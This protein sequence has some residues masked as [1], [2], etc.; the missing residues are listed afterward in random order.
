VNRRMLGR[1]GLEVSAQG[2]GGVASTE[3]VGGD[4]PRNNVVR[5]NLLRDNLPDL[6]SD[7]SGEDN[8][9]PNNSCSSSSPPGLCGDPPQS[10]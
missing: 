3:P 10:P 5:D 4:V 8:D 2:L 7:G 9:F 6:L 1:D